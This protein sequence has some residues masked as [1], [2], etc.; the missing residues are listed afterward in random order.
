MCMKQSIASYCV[1]TTHRCTAIHVSSK[2]RRDA[3]RD[4]RDAEGTQRRGGRR[5]RRDVTPKITLAE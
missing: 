1:A 4:A 3:E 2:G 5:G